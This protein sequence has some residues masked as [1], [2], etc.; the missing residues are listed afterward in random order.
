MCKDR[1][2]VETHLNFKRGVATDRKAN[3]TNA[4]FSSRKVRYAILRRQMAFT[5]RVAPAPKRIEIR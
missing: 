4:S 5:A 2:G 3:T 1:R